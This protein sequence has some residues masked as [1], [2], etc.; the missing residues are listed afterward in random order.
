[1]R[2]QR[3]LLTVLAVLLGA[4]VVVLPAAAGSETTPTI[5]A[6]NSGAYYHYWSPAQV[7]VS[8]GAVVSFSNPY[9]ETHHGLKF[10]GGPATPSCT[11][12]PPAAG[13]ATGALNWHGECTFS[14]PGTYSFVCTVHPGEMK[15][16][17]TVNANGSTTTT[18]TTT[19]P[20]SPE[21]GST[22]ST[23]NGSGPG[24]TTGSPLAGSASQALRLAFNQHGN[25]VHGSVKVSQAGA[26]GRLE[27]DLLA[28]G[29]SIARRAHPAQLPVGRLVHSSLRAGTI[30]FAVPLSARAKRALARHGRL[31]LSVKIVLTPANGSAVTIARSVV[32][33]A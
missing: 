10:T 23:A 32:L 31:A 18:T 12:I 14:T 16:T 8:P 17:V 13:E 2:T 22:P 3:Q 30:S 28:K 19:Q 20:P 24:A 9:T 11:G 25:S 7:F 1:M 4:A 33:H 26:G 21:G 27:I 6:V 5:Q 29:A 15:G